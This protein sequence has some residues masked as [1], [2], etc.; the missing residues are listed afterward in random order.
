MNNLLAGEEVYSEERIFLPG[1]PEGTFLD[2]MGPDINVDMSKY[3]WSDFFDHV[4][5]VG[6]FGFITD[7]LANENR[8]RGVEFFLKPAI[9]QDAHKGVTA[10]L[11]IYDDIKDYGIG[12]GKR[13]A[14][15]LSPIFGT[16]TRRV[17][18]RAETP[19][20]EETYIRYRKGIIKGRILDSF[21]NEKP[22]EAFKILE[23]WNRTYPADGIF[24]ED[25]GPDAIFDRVMKKYEKRMRP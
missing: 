14:K 10:L 19:G 20:Q 8:V 17:A 21:I 9:I 15:H 22:K 13:A 16:V 23:A 5:S 11:S 25:I 3:T 18:K 6:A 24:I 7:I 12:A 2:T 1:L 4:A